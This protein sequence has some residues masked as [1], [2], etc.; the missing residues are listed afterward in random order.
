MG[1]VCWNQHKPLYAPGHITNKEEKERQRQ[2]ETTKINSKHPKKEKRRKISYRLCKTLCSIR[3]FSSR[4]ICGCY[5]IFNMGWC[6]WSSIATGSLDPWVGGCFPSHP[7]RCHQVL[8]TLFPAYSR[9]F[10]YLAGIC[11]LHD[12]TSC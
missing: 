7:T 1:V 9:Y 3:I 2:E 5:P 6:R 12:N 11:S 8:A 4:G 10:S